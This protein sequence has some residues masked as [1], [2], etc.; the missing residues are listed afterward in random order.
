MWPR[1]AKPR[2]L[3][4]SDPLRVIRISNLVFIDSDLL[5]V[6]CRVMRFGDL[7]FIYCASVRLR[8]RPFT[9]DFQSESTIFFDSRSSG[10][11]T[12][13]SSMKRSAY[14]DRSPR[15]RA[16][17]IKMEQREVVRRHATQCLLHPGSQLVQQGPGS[18][19]ADAEP[20][21]GGLAAYLFFDGIE[22][23]DPGQCFGRSRR[24][25]H[26]VNLVELA[27]CMGPAGCLIWLPYR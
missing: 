1:Q 9:P 5:K 4:L 10:G 17:N 3:A 26:H 6:V 8:L 20:E 22:S 19:L 16:R 27:P 14:A 2:C 21:I 12:L 11:T 7:A 13:G 25:V 15:G 24:R 18:R 23:A